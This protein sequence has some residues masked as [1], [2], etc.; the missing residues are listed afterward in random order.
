MGYKKGNA[1]GKNGCIRRE[2]R[3]KEWS[4]RRERH[5]TGWGLR[6]DRAQN[7]MGYKTEVGYKEGL[8]HM[9]V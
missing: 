9:M 3:R 4:I 7:R 2:M 8:G 1:T 5:R 6:R